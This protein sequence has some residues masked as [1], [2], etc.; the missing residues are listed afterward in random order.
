[1]CSSDLGAPHESPPAAPYQTPALALTGIF[2]I[3]CGWWLARPLRRWPRVL[4]PLPVDPLFNSLDPGQPTIL[5]GMALRTLLEAL[6]GRRVV[7]VGSAN[8]R[9]P[10]DREVLR[11]TSGDRL[12][13]EE[14][15][16]ALGKMPGAP[17][18]VVLVGADALSDPG[19]VA[20]HPA[21]KLAKS[22]PPGSWIF[23]LLGEEPGWGWKEWVAPSAPLSSGPG[24]PP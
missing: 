14:A 21:E 7:V 10:A 20:G 8:E 22:L 13:V 19:A 3:A 9:V 15:I 24:H 4:E 1:M 2:G 12:V 11:C 6:G 23:A 17:L 16:T 18:A 5:R